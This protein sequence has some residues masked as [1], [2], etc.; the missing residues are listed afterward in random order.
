MTTQ[1]TVRTPVQESTVTVDPLRYV[2]ANELCD[3]QRKWMAYDAF[4]AL[5]AHGF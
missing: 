1:T 2:Q 3:T 4:A 5:T